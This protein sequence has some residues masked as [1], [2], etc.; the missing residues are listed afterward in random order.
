MWLALALRT[1][2]LGVVW[3]EPELVGPLVLATADEEVTVGVSTAPE[4]MGVSP[5][6]MLMKPVT[7]EREASVMTDETDSGLGR[8]MGMGVPTMLLSVLEPSQVNSMH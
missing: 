2:A 4:E 1:A 7:E 6:G 5:A 8:G 3:G